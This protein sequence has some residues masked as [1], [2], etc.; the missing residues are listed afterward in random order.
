[1]VS[2]VFVR[3]GWLCRERPA[4]FAHHTTATQTLNI[5]DTAT[6]LMCRVCQHPFPAMRMWYHTDAFEW[7]S[8]LPSLPPEGRWVTPLQ[9]LACPP[10]ISHHSHQPF[11]TKLRCHGLFPPHRVRPTTTQSQD[12]GSAADCA[13]MHSIRSKQ[14]LEEATVSPTLSSLREL[15][16]TVS[17]LPAL[18]ADHPLSM[19]VACCVVVGI[20]INHPWALP[21]PCPILSSLLS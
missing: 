14:Q 19:A 11:R 15:W 17:S 21:L 9:A 13:A 20:Y 5:D 18:P 12:Q 1:M 3:C 7:R 4:K 6:K 16:T 2:C 8:L 10:S